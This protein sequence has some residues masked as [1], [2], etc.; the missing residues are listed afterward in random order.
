MLSAGVIEPIAELRGGSE[1]REDN[2]LKE[3]VIMQ[4][5]GCD[6]VVDSPYPKFRILAPDVFTVTVPSYTCDNPEQLLR[7]FAQ[8]IHGAR[9]RDHTSKLEAI[10]PILVGRPCNPGDANYP[11]S[12]TFFT[13]ACAASVRRLADRPSPPTMEAVKGFLQDHEI[14]VDMRALQMPLSATVKDLFARQSAQL[15]AHTALQPEELPE[16]AE[17]LERIQKDPPNPPLD[18]KQLCM[19]RSELRALVPAIHEVIDR[20]TLSASRRQQA[21]EEAAEK[22]RV[23]MLKVLD[24]MHREVLLDVLD[25]W[26]A[27]AH[28]S[29]RLLER[30][31]RRVPTADAGGLRCEFLGLAARPVTVIASLIFLQQKGQVSLLV[32]LKLQT[33]TGEEVS[34]ALVLLYLS[35]ISKHNL[36]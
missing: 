21:I 28:D 11:C 31:L 17:W 20:A 9:L 23:L 4:A 3:L 18:P 8:A 35:L 34:I 32:S 25:A 10:Y 26:R 7:I 5:C 12:G 6:Q 22:R 2:V 24:R 19:L 13:E 1:D 36:C 29:E 27:S 16:E 30:K 33:R 15:W 14:S